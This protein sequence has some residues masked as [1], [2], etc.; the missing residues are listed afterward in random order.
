MGNR[1]TSSELK[2]NYL[3]VVDS[4]ELVAGFKK[5]DLSSTTLK[6]YIHRPTVSSL[7]V[8]QG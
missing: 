6:L 5:M 8:G 3:F 2:I 4:I 1:I 7:N